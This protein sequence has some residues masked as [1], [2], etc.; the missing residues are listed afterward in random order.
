MK[1][2][3]HGADRGV[4]GSCHLVE[5][6]GRRIL[7]DCGLYQGG[8]EIEEDN[9]APFGFDA[10][11]H[12][13]RAADPRASR[14][15]RAPAAAREA[16]LS[17]RD[18]H[19][20]GLARAGAARAARC[21]PPAGGGGPPPRAPA[22]RDAAAETAAASRS[23]PSIDALGTFRLL[24][25][26]RG[27][28]DADRSRRGASARRSSTPATSSAR[29]ASSS[30][31]RRAS[32]RRRVL[33]SGD[34]GNSGRPLL[35]DPPR[36]RDADVVVM[37]TTYGD[38]LHKPLAPSVEELYAAIGDTFARGGNVIIPTF[39]LE[40]AQ[41]LLYY[42]REGIEKN[43][44]TPRDPGVPRF[45]DGDL[46]DRDLPAPSGVLRPGDDGALP[47]GARPVRPAG[48]AFRARER[49]L[50]RAE[51]D[52]RRRVIMAGSGMCTG[53]RM[54]HH[55]RHNLWRRDA[56]VVF[57]G[58][59][60]KGTLAREIIDGAK[61]VS[62]FGERIPVRAR[63]HTI[64]GFSAHADQAELLAWHRKT[65]RARTFLVHGEE[66]AMRSF[67]GQAFRHARGD[68]FGRRDVRALAGKVAFAATVKAVAVLVL[69]WGHGVISAAKE[70]R[71]WRHQTQ[72]N[73]ALSRSAAIPEVNRLGFGAMRITGRGIWGEP[74]RPCRGDPHA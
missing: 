61:E 62:I 59:A 56:S 36:R 46:G 60:A 68:A 27:L 53:G 38:R 66:S 13:L 14:P 63:I 11:G 58:F 30:S 29:R 33:F 45:A 51:P 50:D 21:R 47:R 35:R 25:P 10:A 5:C 44:L 17:R 34:L 39:A 1:L 20:G 18:H 9:A 16:R 54:R 41:E 28:R 73:P 55:L 65:R 2:S 70:R 42:L 64:N 22:R 57:V 74:D 4:T 72:R 24:R 49:R 52:H 31:W 32:R 19:H 43:A 48:P 23:T 69:I 6:A 12:R 71:M 67:R 8:H 40:R 37:E 3:F 26:R 7:I 15:L